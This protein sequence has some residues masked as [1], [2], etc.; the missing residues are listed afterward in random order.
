MERTPEREVMVRASCSE[1]LEPALEPHMK[2]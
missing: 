2:V 1:Y